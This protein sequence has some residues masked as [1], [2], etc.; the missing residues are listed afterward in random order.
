M[1]KDVVSEKFEYLFLNKSLQQRLV[2]YKSDAGHITVNKRVAVYFLL[3]L[4]ISE[5]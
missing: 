2:G 1:T 4:D 3:V 5:I